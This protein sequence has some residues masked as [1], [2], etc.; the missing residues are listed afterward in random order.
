M[1]SA[2]LF[3]VTS[4]V[5]CIATVIAPVSS[6]RN[7]QTPPGLDLEYSFRQSTVTLNE[8]VVLLFS[9]HNGLS[10]PVTLTLGALNI[11]F[12][13]FTL[14]TPDGRT[15]SSS[16]AVGQSLGAIVFD[17]QGKATIQ[18]GVDYEQAI[19][20]NQWFHFSMPGTYSLTSKLITNVE[21]QNGDFSA[22]SHTLQLRVSSRYPDRLREICARLAE[23]AEAAPNVAGARAPALALS[24]VED[25]IAVPYLDHLLRSHSLT[26]DLAVNGLERIGDNE[27]VAALLSALD[28]DYGDI[29]ELATQALG[30]MGGRMSSPQV[31]ETV[32][33]AVA[34]SL[35]RERNKYIRTQI[36][37]L[38]YHSPT[39]Q[40]AA[41]QNLMKVED[42]LRQAEPDLQ[43][44]ANDQSQ[45][46]DVRAAA[47]EA[48]QKLHHPDSRP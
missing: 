41:I 37:Y 25:P 5:W 19:L 36:A 7:S 3:V 27:A 21:S 12:F 47:K 28:D 17:G 14:T 9:V 2:A 16:A 40:R 32:A 15:L 13:H 18:P 44:L 46:L 31:R 45:P 1:R 22:P 42:G 24:Y 35:A 48:L 39:L 29:S 6:P 8:P 10:Q 43:R 33:E 38:D 34:R 11:Q 4:C 23:E 20:M 30:R 26:Y